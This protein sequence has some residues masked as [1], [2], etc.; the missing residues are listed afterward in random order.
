MAYTI[1]KANYFYVTVQDQPGEAYEL[2]AQLSGLG[3]N[4][5]AFTA[6]PIGPSS[7][8]FAIFPDDDLNLRSV[9]GKAGLKLD[10][11]YPAFLVQGDD[12]LG[13]LS[14]VHHKFYLAKVNI[15]ASSGVSDG[16]GS[17]GYVIYVRPADF[18]KAAEAMGVA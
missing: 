11:P 8:Q 9:A 7:T 15:Y 1:R 14:E 18:E 4:L 2:L 12:E 13:A 16:R 5:L 10:G 3:I 6:I 17:Y